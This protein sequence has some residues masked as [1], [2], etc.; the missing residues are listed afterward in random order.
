M[1]DPVTTG[2]IVGATVLS[3]GASAYQGHQQRK[4]AKSARQAE[5][6]VQAEQRKQALAQRKD[7]IDQQREG[8]YGHYK[9]DTGAGMQQGLYGKLT[10][11]TLG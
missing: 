3:T 9:T 10:D 8:L 11:D 1:G 4:A 6:R 7:L 5:E 2:L